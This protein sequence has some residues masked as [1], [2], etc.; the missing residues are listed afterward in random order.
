MEK[1]YQS[2]PSPL[3]GIARV[4]LADELGQKDRRDRMLDEV[5]AQ[6]QGKVPRMVTICK[7]IRDSLAEGRNPPL[8]LAAVDKVLDSMP[9]KNRVDADFFVGRYLLSR[10]QTDAARKYLKRCGEA[11]ENHVWPA[12]LAI[13]ALRSQDARKN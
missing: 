10:H 6:F 2:T 7:M 8:D 4:L 3:N 1:A 12:L 11:A 5:T 9:A 13:D